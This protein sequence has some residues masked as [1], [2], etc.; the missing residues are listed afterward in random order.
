[1]VMMLVVDWYVKQLLII[2][3][4]LF[5]LVNISLSGG[6]DARTSDGSRDGRR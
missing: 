4:K 2:R 5:R 3:F 6:V 1:V